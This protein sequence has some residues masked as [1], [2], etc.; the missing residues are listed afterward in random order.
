MILFMYTIW[1]LIITHHIDY[2]Q[3]QFS[4]GTYGSSGPEVRALKGRG[5]TGRCECNDSCTSIKTSLTTG[6]RP[7]GASPNG[8]NDSRWSSFMH[9]SVV[10]APSSLFLP[11]P[12]R[13]SHWSSLT[14][15]SM[16][17]SICCIFTKTTY[18]ICY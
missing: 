17:S 6:L 14:T 1:Q 15:P 10:R 18:K 8:M 16:H 7:K 11:R 3:Y 5:L 13:S 12:I 4:I 2:N 9:S